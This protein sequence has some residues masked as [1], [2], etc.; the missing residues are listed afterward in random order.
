MTVPVRYYCPRC[1]AIASL[2]RD[3]A[4]ADKSVTPY[5]AE[6]WEYADSHEDFE[7]ADGVRLVCGED[8]A[9]AGCG[10]VFYLNFLRFEKGV[11]IEPTPESEFVELNVGP[12]T[13]GPR[14]P[15]DYA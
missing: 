12:P 14:R 5:P 4:L 13:P 8:T 7:S 10:E 6:G 15:G 1:G 9:D 11:E 3:E 2:D